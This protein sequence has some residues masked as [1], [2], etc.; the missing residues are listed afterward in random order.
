MHYICRIVTPKGI[1][2]RVYKTSLGDAWRLYNDQYGSCAFSAWYRG[3][4]SVHTADGAWVGVVQKHYE[5]NED[6]Q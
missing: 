4:S 1:H 3:F 5:H 2:R 6:T